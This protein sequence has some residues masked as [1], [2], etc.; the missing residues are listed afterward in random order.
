MGA[1]LDINSIEKIVIFAK[2]IMVRI[3]LIVFTIIFFT[4]GC[5]EKTGESVVLDKENKDSTNVIDVNENEKEYGLP[6]ASQIAVIFNKADLK[7]MPEITS[8]ID[9]EAA[10]GTFEFAIRLGIYSA[11]FFYCIL[12]NQLEEAKNY[13]L[14]CNNLTE[15]LG[16][17]DIF[18][19]TIMT[20]IER[21]IN[22]KDS[23]ISALSEI[24]Y[25]MD[26][27]IQSEN[28]EYIQHIA[29]AGGWIE[30]MHIAVKVYEKNHQNKSIPYLLTEQIMIGE[31]LLSMFENDKK[32]E[33]N[34]ARLSSD[35]T[36][37]VKVFKSL[38]TI[39]DSQNADDK[40]IVL[41]DE[42]LKII[43][44]KINVLHQ[45]IIGY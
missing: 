34:V 1:K 23:I 32:M 10:G 44:E 14:K 19:K 4:V 43:S 41:T 20:K 31:T 6:S 26:N 37:L 16:M 7:Y 42:E 28:K 5:S 38:K 25:V 27:Y 22:N 29:F 2:K 24:Q 40:E 12:N 8:K 30:S 9:N 39:Q 13:F 36:E 33:P 11:D 3:G 45:K 18:T 35:I 17:K 21:N 15:K